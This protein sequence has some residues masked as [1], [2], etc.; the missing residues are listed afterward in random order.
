MVLHAEHGMLAMPQPFD[1]AVVQVD[2][3][4]LDVGR[5]RLR[6]DGKAVVLRG[7]FH[8]AGLEL[9]HRMVRAA[10]SEFELERVAAHRQAKNLMTE[11]DSEYRHVGFDEHLRVV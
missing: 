6:I 8:L 7:D 4:D 11:A 5:K 1:R 10:M 9:L 3:S 2:V